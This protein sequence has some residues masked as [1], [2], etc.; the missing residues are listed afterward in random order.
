MVPFAHGEW[1]GGRVP[2]G[3]AHRLPADGHLSL[4]GRSIGTIL[5]ALLEA[6]GTPA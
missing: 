1:L 2:A 5:D 4:V 3:P 6:A